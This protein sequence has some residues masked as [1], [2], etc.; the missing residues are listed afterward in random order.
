MN[1]FRGYSVVEQDFNTRGA[2]IAPYQHRKG[3]GTLFVLNVLGFV[4][5]SKLFISFALL[6]LQRREARVRDGSD[7]P[8]PRRWVGVKADS[9]APYMPLAYRGKRPKNCSLKKIIGEIQPH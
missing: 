8:G 7:Y 2:T 4:G 1:L 9:P 3:H 5:V 6:P